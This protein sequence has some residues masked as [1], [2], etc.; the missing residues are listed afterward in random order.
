MRT[1]SICS[2]CSL[3]LTL[4]VSHSI[5]NRAEHNVL[6]IIIDGNLFSTSFGLCL[7]YACCGECVVW[8]TYATHCVCSMMLMMMTTVKS[9]FWTYINRNYILIRLPTRRASANNID[10]KKNEM[11]KMKDKVLPMNYGATGRWIGTEK[12][13]RW[14]IHGRKNSDAIN[15]QF[16]LRRMED[17]GENSTFP[18]AFRRT[19]CGCV[20]VTFDVHVHHVRNSADEIDF[21]WDVAHGAL[22]QCAQHTFGTRF[23]R[24]SFIGN[25]SK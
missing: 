7:P 14:K 3:P 19:W 13:G 8:Q 5:Y 15:V 22:I 16:K 2:F 18:F 21:E 9:A 17:E 4:C 25:R 23:S 1:F 6:H 20:C 12:N 11:K 24:T 10:S